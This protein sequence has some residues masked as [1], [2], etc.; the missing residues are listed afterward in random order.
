MR[1]FLRVFVGLLL[2]AVLVG[3]GR[4]SRSGVV[5][6]KITYKE[7]PVNDAALRLYPADG[8]AAE[9]ITIPVTADGSF[10]MSDVPKGEYK[11][12]VQGSEGGGSDASL[13]K[14]VPKDRQEEVKKLM[15]DR[16]S[17]RTIPFPRKYKNL[18]TTDLKC[19][20]TDHD[21]TLNL[22]LKD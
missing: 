16:A 22:E 8:G 7:Q 4:R 6:G 21:Q 14:N 9:P 1:P 3:C 15:G 10:S 11:I 12:I 13:L 5:S 2:V 18:K 20:I 19:E 17:S